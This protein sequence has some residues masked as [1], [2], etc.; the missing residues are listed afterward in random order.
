[1]KMDLKRGTLFLLVFL[2]FHHVSYCQLHILNPSFEGIPRLPA[3]GPPPFF[4]KNCLVD[5]PLTNDTSTVDVQDSIDN[6]DCPRDG[7]TMVLLV[8][9]AFD[10]N[11]ESCSGKLV[12]SAL[13]P[14]VRYKFSIQAFVENG[15]FYIKPP[16]FKMWWGNDVCDTAQL[17]YSEI[18]SSA[19]SFLPYW[20]KL[21]STFTANDSFR[22]IKLKCKYVGPDSLNYYS[23]IKLDNLSPIAPD[24]IYNS[25]QTPIV[26]SNAYPCVGDAITLTSPYT[27]EPEQHWYANGSP[28][29]QGV[30]VTHHPQMTT[31]YTVTLG[32]DSCI[33]SVLQ[34]TVVVECGDA[35]ELLLPDAFTPNGDGKNDIFHILNSAMLIANGY[36]IR[37]VQIYN[38]WGNRVYTSEVDW[39]FHWDGGNNAGD[40][41]FYMI[42]YFNPDKK[43]RMIKGNVTVVR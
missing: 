39:D 19:D 6:I 37:D 24:T 30:Q 29:G 18:V 9:Y 32:R 20:R 23:Y 31:K 42:R 41:Y 28:I 26:C 12:C 40:V 14:G 34:R 22:F 27:D 35:K 16:L 5:Y 7:K 38:R 33:R 11:N 4:W 8:A 2:F 17:V 13:K 21:Y 10:K 3:N 25:A 36:K 15:N 1:M 43:E